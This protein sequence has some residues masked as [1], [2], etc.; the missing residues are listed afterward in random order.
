[1]KTAIEVLKHSI[2]TQQS[3]VVRLNAEIEDMEDSL[4]NKR[5]IVYEHLNQIT[6]ME[7]AVAV[8]EYQQKQEADFNKIVVGAKKGKK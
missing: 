3:E 4:E 1:M 8:L 6:E 2:S 7:V 5:V